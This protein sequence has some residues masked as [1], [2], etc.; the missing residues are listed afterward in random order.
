MVG[1]MILLCRLTQ[2]L[3]LELGAHGLLITHYL[4]VHMMEKWTQRGEHQRVVLTL[5]LL[6]LVACSQGGTQS[7]VTANTEVQITPPITF[8]DNGY[9]AL[10]IPSGS[11]PVYLSK[12]STSRFRLLKT[13]N[14]GSYVYWLAVGY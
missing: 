13:A 5:C 4:F 8:S 9:T 10:A 14:V 11:T 1:I 7:G 12:D 2:Q 6:L 3:R